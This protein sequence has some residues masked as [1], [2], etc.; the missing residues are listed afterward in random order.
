MESSHLV[1]KRFAS[2]E[3]APLYR[4][5]EFKAASLTEAAIVCKGTVGGKPT[6][7][8]IFTDVTGQKYV[9]LITLQLLDSIVQVGNATM[10]SEQ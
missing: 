8:L 4:P 9:A 5:P 3:E 7:D 10:S 6:V 2:V 1:V